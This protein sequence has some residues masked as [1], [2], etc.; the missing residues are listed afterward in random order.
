MQLHISNN[1]LRLDAASGTV[2]RC[3]DAFSMLYIGR[4]EETVDMYRGNFFIRRTS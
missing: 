3:D 4:G 1:T 2:L